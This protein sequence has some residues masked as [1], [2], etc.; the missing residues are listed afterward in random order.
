L[1]KDDEAPEMA[2]EAKL[3]LVRALTTTADLR[4]DPG[5][6]GPATKKNLKLIYLSKFYDI[7]QYIY[8]NFIILA[9]PKFK[10]QCL[11]SIQIILV[12]RTLSSSS[13]TD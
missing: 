2:T 8:D 11:R 6:G 7:L 10:V 12:F 9:P 1:F 5:G 4:R 13:A 3:S